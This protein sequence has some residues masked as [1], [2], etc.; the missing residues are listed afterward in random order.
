MIMAYEAQ[1]LRDSFCLELGRVTSALS[2]TSFLQGRHA[3]RVT[4]TCV[5]LRSRGFWL[6]P[7][8][9]RGQTNSLTRKGRL[10]TTLLL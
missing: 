1:E 5:P 8:S 6:Q 9:Y 2:G 4:V 3:I 10:L 7:P